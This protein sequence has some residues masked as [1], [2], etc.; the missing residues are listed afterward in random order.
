MRDA[1]TALVPLFAFMLLP[2][3]IPLVALAV[4]RIGELFGGREHDAV[5]ARFAAVKERSQAQ[6]E[7]AA[8]SYAGRQAAL[9]AA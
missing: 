7:Q 1:L 9:E 3:W 6:R 4:G 8:P 5:V 2:V